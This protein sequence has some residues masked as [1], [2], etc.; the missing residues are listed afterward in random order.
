MAVLIGSGVFI[1]TSRGAVG[2]HFRSP[3]PPFASLSP[4]PPATTVGRRGARLT[5]VEGLAIPQRWWELFHCPALNSILTRAISANPDLQAAQAA[6]R[7]ADANMQAARGSFF[8]QIDANVGASSQRPNPAQT[9]P[10]G[11]ITS[12]YCVPLGQR[13]ASIGLDV[14]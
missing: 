13:S 3:P 2:P 10:P 5:Y 4:T 9:Q 6:L 7:I 11:N 12:P 14:F 8:P 1:L